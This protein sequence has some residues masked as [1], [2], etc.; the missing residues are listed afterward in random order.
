MHVSVLKCSSL[1][2]FLPLESSLLDGK[3]AVFDASKHH[4]LGSDVEPSAKSMG[5][6]EALITRNTRQEISMKSDATRC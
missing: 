4:L 2:V 3:I 6:F 1:I 5:D